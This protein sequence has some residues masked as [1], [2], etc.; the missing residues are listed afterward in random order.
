MMWLTLLIAWFAGL[1][2]GAVFMAMFSWSRLRDTRAALSALAEY[3]RI[4][5]EQNRDLKAQKFAARKEGDMIV[6]KW[7]MPQ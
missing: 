7:A 5:E 1:F 2:S 6:P 4:L 3:A